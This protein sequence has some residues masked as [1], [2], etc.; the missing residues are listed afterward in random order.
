MSV[1]IITFVA[2]FNLYLNLGAGWLSCFVFRLGWTAGRRALTI[3]TCDLLPIWH[4]LKPALSWPAVF[5]WMI[6][7]R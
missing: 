2:F 4:Q 3:P 7:S 1:V 5:V 6:A